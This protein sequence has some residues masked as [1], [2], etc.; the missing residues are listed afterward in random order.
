MAP[1]VTAVEL[2]E[3]IRM[4]GLAAQRDLDRITDQERAHFANAPAIAFAEWLRAEQ[5]LS[6]FQA[7]QLLLGKWRRLRFQNYVILDRL[8]AG[9]MGCVFRADH[10][11]LRRKVALKVL[12]EILAA[13]PLIKE[14]F[15]R[16]AHVLALLDHPHIVRTYD[17]DETDGIPFLTME[18]V[19]GCNLKEQVSHYGPLSAKQATD[20][21]CQ[22]AAGLHYAFDQ[23]ELA[24]GDLKPSNLLV[25]AKARLKILDFGLSSFRNEVT[26]DVG[27]PDFVA[28]ERALKTSAVNAGSDIY[29]LGVTFYF[30]L[31]G[32]VWNAGRSRDTSDP[33]SAQSVEQ[34]LMRM[35]ADVSPALGGVIERMVAIDPRER[36]ST[37]IE[38]VKALHGL[39]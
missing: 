13:D 30:I 27:T 15:R 37:P 9:G 10:V 29:S 33:S 32:H 36:F 7:E 24:H 14:R 39:T 21:I 18:Y 8:G 17:Y 35:R 22:A 2:L 19:E 4:S 26:S 11:L 23:A 38:I 25:D 28:P 5:V 3:L 16:E 20:L 31:T 1:P 12:P 34:S 6:E